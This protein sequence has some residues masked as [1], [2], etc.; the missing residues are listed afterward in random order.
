MAP[1]DDLSP[2]ERARIAPYVTDPVAPVFALTHLPE[3]VKGALFARYSRSANSV[4]RI[5][6]DEFVPDTGD[7]GAPQGQDPD[8]TRARSSAS[9]SPSPPCDSR[10][11]HRP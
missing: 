5:L 4:R 6:L 1:G 8:R 11:R 2:E 10:S 9:P 3:A 7:G